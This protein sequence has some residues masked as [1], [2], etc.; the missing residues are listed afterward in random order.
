MKHRNTAVNKLKRSASGFSLPEV[1][2]VV[3]LILIIAALAVPSFNH[4]Y[5]TFRVKDAA[6]RVASVLRFTRFEAIRKNI[7]VNCLIRNV[8]NVPNI[9]TDSNGDGVKQPTENQAALTGGIS[10][11]TSGNIPN[12]GALA[13]AIGVGGLTAVSPTD[14]NTLTFDNRG[15]VNPAGVYVI[16]MQNTGNPIKEYRAVVVLPSGSIQ[17]WAAGSDGQWRQAN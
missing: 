4:A 1:V 11:S 17:T 12:Q 15:A 9:W 6:V 3:V 14:V 5:Q 16:C 8:G 2:M 7:T 10:F 13:G